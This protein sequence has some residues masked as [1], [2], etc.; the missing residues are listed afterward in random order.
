[1][2]F[3]SESAHWKNLQ[4]PWFCI[5]IKPLYLDQDKHQLQTKAKV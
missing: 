1:M 5:K 4:A 2:L 3:P